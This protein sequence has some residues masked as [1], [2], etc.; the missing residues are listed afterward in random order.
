VSSIAAPIHLATDN[1]SPI[2]ILARSIR[3]RE[4]RKTVLEGHTIAHL[5]LKLL[6]TLAISL[7]SHRERIQLPVH[8]N[9]H[10]LTGVEAHENLIWQILAQQ[11]HLGAHDIA[12]QTPIA[13]GQVNAHE[14][15]VLPILIMRPS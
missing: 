6:R 1:V 9:G 15:G 10:V 12:V 8:R 2:V 11:V 4:F 5:R 13:P 3:A 14:P 7:G